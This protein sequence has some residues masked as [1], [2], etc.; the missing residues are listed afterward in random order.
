MD[1]PR[2]WLRYVA[3]GD[4]SETD[5]TFAGLPV[6][7]AEGEK[8]GKIDGFIVDANTARPY[9]VVVDSGGWFKSKRYLV[10]IGHAA[11]DPGRKVLLADLSRERIKR[12][13]GFDKDE[14]ET[15]SEQELQQFAESTA[16]AC[17]VTEIVVVSEVRPW[18]EWRPLYQQPGWWQTSF[19]N[20]ERAGAAGVTAGAEIPSKREREPAEREPAMARDTSKR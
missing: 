13:P 17:T 16:S 7:N 19:Y 8:L 14:F 1:R 6:E 5:V 2:S 9:Y 11:L 15:L 10:P 12:F 20:P 4:L 3:A 18:S